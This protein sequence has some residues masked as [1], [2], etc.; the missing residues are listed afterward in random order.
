MANV[1]VEPKKPLER[2]IE[3]FNYILD[4]LQKDLEH[5]HAEKAVLIAEIE[6]IQQALQDMETNK[7]KEK[8]LGLITTS[9]FLQWKEDYLE[10][11]TTLD[12]QKNKL[13]V[14]TSNIWQVEQKIE[15]EYLKSKSFD[16]KTENKL[17]FNSLYQS[18]N[19]DQKQAYNA[20]KTQLEQRFNNP[21][22]EQKLEQVQAR[23]LEKYK[24]NPNFAVPQQEQQQD[25]VRGSSQ[26]KGSSRGR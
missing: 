18:L 4:R 23:F 8:F 3:P 19:N 1:H 12:T 10:L 2:K 11:K 14:A 5:A 26:T 20:L 25:L 7:P 21:Q 9:E 22:L 6:K 17:D 24:E 15:K 16:Q 13:S